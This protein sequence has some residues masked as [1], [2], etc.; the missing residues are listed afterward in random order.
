MLAV[1]HRH[2]KGVRDICRTLDR[3]QAEAHGDHC[4]NLI[5]VGAPGSRDRHLHLRRRILG[6]VDASGCDRGHDDSRRPGDGHGGVSVP[7]DEYLLDRSCVDCVVAED[8]K[9]VVA[10][11]QKLVLCWS[12]QVTDTGLAHLKGLPQ[13]KGL[14]LW[15]VDVTDAGL[16]QLKDL[17]TLH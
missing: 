4:S 2:T 10:Q 14:E 3:G 7:I 15:G 9:D 16:L 11:L 13:L 1:A 6:D 5:L 17:T 8:S 12:S